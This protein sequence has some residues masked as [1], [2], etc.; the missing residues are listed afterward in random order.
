MTHLVI[1]FVIGVLSSATAAGLLFLRRKARYRMRFPAVLKLIE[2]L[3]GAINRD[4][5]HFDHLITI[6]RN[7]GVAG[8]ILAGQFGLEATV[9][10]SP[11]KARLP[12]GERTIAL[13][14][15]GETLLPKLG[16][17]RVLIFICCNDSGAT[18]AYVVE[19]LKG[20]DFP[21]AEIRTAA[22]YTSPS[23][24]F[25]PTY[26]AVV[27][28]QTSRRSMTKVLENLPWVTEGWR[29]PFEDERRRR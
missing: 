8:S 7:S 27:L 3:S 12:S 15:I 14:D 26:R 16:G 1:S 22:L 19:R 20:S 23:P 11:R 18:L 17:A 24:S 25:M 10:V 6:G 13:D 28:E 4:A 29:H 2:S 5:F 21:P 9:S